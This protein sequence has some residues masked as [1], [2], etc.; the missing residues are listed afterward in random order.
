VSLGKRCDEQQVYSL[1]LP[2]NDLTDL[3]TRTVTQ[4]DQVLV[5]ARYDV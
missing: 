5:W 3:L 1:S 2:D 4:V